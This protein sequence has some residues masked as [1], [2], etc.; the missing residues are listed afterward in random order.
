MTTATQSQASGPKPIDLAHQDAGQASFL[1]TNIDAFI[2]WGRGNSLW[3][4]PFGTA[5]CA[6][7]YMAAMSSRFDFAR[8]ATEFM[9]FTPRQSDMLLVMGTVTYK[10]APILRRIWEQMAEPKWVLSFGACACSGGFYDCYCTVPGI[11][12]I[13]PVDVYIAGCPPRPEAYMEA[14]MLLQ[15]KIK[16]ESY[17]E[18]RRQGL[19]Q[20]VYIG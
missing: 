1:T 16:D 11:D 19:Q 7:E 10:Q 15:E 8:F 4:F 13:V 2:N 3:P 18:Q 14:A 12:E 6:I 9:R 20:K 5:C 17:M